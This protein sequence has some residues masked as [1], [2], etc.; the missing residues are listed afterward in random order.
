[1]LVVSDLDEV[2]VPLQRGLFVNPV[3]RRYVFRC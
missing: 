1:M 3:E 2:F